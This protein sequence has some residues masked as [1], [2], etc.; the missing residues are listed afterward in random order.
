MTSTLAGVF[1][2]SQPYRMSLRGTPPHEPAALFPS[3]AAADPAQAEAVLEGGFLL[4]G[5]RFPFGSMPWSALPPGAVLAERMHEFGWLVDLRGLGSE[6]ARQRARALTAGWLA[7]HRR[8]TTP[9]WQPPVLARRLA[10]WLAASDFLLSAAEPGFRLGFLQAAGAQARHLLRVAGGCTGEASAFAIVLGRIAA[11][12]ALGVGDVGRALDQLNREIDLQILPDG[13][14]IGRNPATQLA[15]LRDLVDIRAGL[16]IVAKAPPPAAASA[17]ERMAPILRAFRHAD[18]GLAL[19]HG[20]KEL[21]RGVIDTV[22]VASNVKE[23]APIGMPDSRYTRLAAGR[24]LI[25][26]DVGAPPA[27]GDGHAGLLA[28]EMSDGRDR[29]VVNCGGFAGDSHRWRTALRSTAAHSTLAL[30]ESNA[31]EVSRGFWGQ[32]AKPK[33]EAER[34]ET[35]GA[36]WLEASHDGYRRRY[37]LIHRRRLYLDATGCDLRGE[38]SLEGRGHGAPFRLRFHLH[39]D[40]TAALAEDGRSV[41]LKTQGGGWRFLCV[42]GA[43][44]LDESAYLGRSDKPEK[45]QQIVVAGTAGGSGGGGGS[46]SDTAAQ[47]KWAFRRQGAAP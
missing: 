34:R 36:I 25:I 11:A 12:V 24:S 37:G 6:P 15:V 10:N 1:Y 20:A 39:P 42:G 33:I 2:R 45:A 43:I 26:A 14:H 47:L 19:F 21:N 9:A 38:D 40:V 28:F 18:G 44:S 41:L 31:A 5:R 27:T 32:R 13:G 3:L 4:G 29:L 8:W 16:A 30:G 46:G 22:L 7:S 35:D 17:I 23:R